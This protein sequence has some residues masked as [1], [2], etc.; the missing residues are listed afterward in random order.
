MGGEIR[1][2]LDAKNRFYIFP[3]YGLIYTSIRFRVRF[4]FIFTII[5]SSSSDKWITQLP[6]NCIVQFQHVIGSHSFLILIIK[7]TDIVP[8]TGQLSAHI[9]H[10]S[11]HNIRRVGV[12]QRILRGVQRRHKQCH[13][14]GNTDT[15]NGDSQSD[16]NQIEC[17]SF[18]LHKSLNL[19]N[20]YGYDIFL[21]SEY[22]KSATI[23]PC[24]TSRI[25]KYDTGTS[26]DTKTPC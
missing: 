24:R 17:R 11:I 9:S 13:D 1:I 19:Q 10:K 12:R 26:Q 6:I 14:C 25:E 21:E 3:L 7:I 23:Q 18:C 15:D 4:L 2:N 22:K 20:Q 16:L 8:I 5:D